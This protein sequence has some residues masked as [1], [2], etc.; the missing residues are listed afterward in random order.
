MSATITQ[1]QWDGLPDRDRNL[2]K[3]MGIK[4]ETKAPVKEKLLGNSNPVTKARKLGVIHTAPTEYYMQVR[5][6]CE[7]CDGVSIKEGKMT[8]LQPRDRML[9]FVEGEVPSGS[10]LKLKLL[11]PV[12]CGKCVKRLLELSKEELVEKVM[13][14][15]TDAVMKGWL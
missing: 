7:C 1:E 2:L 9:V 15:T 3:Q 6:T 12:N 11:A 4:P 10:C 8:L 13:R 5:A 14:L